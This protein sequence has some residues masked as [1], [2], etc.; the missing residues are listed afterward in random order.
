MKPWR[1]AWNGLLALVA[2][3]SLA[4]SLRAEVPRALAAAL[5]NLR[6]QRSYSWEIINADPGPV[7]QSTET[8]AGACRWS[9]KI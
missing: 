7:A 3:N 8:A 1:L 5:Q 2:V 9:N 6:E 4:L